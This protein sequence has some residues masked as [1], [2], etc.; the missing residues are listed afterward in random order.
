MEQDNYIYYSVS[1]LVALNLPDFPTSRQG[2]DAHVKR[3]NWPFKEEKGL[4]GPGGVKRVYLPPPDLRRQIEIQRRIHDATAG[5]IP[6]HMNELAK[7]RMREAAGALAPG[8]ADPDLAPFGTSLNVETVRPSSELQAK[9]IFALMD[10]SE[11][12][13]GLTLDQRTAL[14]MRLFD[15][16]M[17]SCGSDAAKL[18][19]VIETPDALKGALRLAWELYRSDI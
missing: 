12:P 1:D 16:L 11:I 8:P 4:G 13:P 6:L 7:A 15:L 3:E 17:M 19:R 14:T 18:K 9:A 2:V 5:N 10:M